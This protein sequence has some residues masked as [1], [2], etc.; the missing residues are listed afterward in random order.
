M[1]GRSDDKDALKQ[2]YSRLLNFFSD[3]VSEYLL[4]YRGELIDGIQY[5]TSGL[6]GIALDSI[7]VK[8][9]YKPYYTATPA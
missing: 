1:L 4:T 8:V 5:S 7:K 2:G 9:Q 3:P 6:K